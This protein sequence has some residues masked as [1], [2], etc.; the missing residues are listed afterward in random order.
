[1]I[2]TSVGCCSQMCIV[3]KF[4]GH[5]SAVFFGFGC[6]RAW[7]LSKCGERYTCASSAEVLEV[8]CVISDTLSVTV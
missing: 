2:S 6:E 8:E 4:T 5:G 7:I 3:S 1:M